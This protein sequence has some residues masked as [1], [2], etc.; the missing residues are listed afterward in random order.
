MKTCTNKIS[1]FPLQ[2]RKTSEKLP[3]DNNLCLVPCSCPSITSGYVFDRCKVCVPSGVW[4]WGC[5]EEVLGVLVC[6]GPSVC[7]CR[8]RGGDGA[9]SWGV[10]HLTLSKTVS[11]PS[12]LYPQQEI[13]CYLALRNRKPKDAFLPGHFSEARFSLGC[14]AQ[15]TS[16]V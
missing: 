5:R 2:K 16:H 13:W 15:E 7:G 10:R 3:L 9:P 11:E 4:L 12:R 6:A 14:G 1:N 8:C